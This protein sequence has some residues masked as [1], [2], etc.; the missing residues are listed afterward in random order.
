MQYLKKHVDREMAGNF[1]GLV[2]L[3]DQFYIGIIV[4]NEN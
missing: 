3:G 1:N 4:S 2:V